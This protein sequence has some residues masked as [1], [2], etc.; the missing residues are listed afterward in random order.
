MTLVPQSH[1]ILSP[2]VEFWFLIFFKRFYYGTL[3]CLNGFI[4][5]LKK[6]WFHFDSSNLQNGTFFILRIIWCQDLVFIIDGILSKLFLDKSVGCC[7]I[8][9]AFKFFNFID[10]L[11]Y[12]EMKIML[13]INTLVVYTLAHK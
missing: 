6:K 3:S 13:E 9:I 5:V 7:N 10:W 8:F 1:R 4:L 12:L 2:M 11:T